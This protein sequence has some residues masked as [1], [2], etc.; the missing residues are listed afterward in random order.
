MPSTLYGKNI[1]LT[2]EKVP[3][4]LMAHNIQALGG[5]PIILPVMKI[6]HNKLSHAECE[7]LMQASQFDWIVFTSPNGVKAFMDNVKSLN[8]NLTNTKIAVVGK[9]NSPSGKCLGIKYR[10]D[11]RRIYSGKFGRKFG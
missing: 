5:N 2:R 3:S 7:I 11:T 6:I 1:L 4:E 9:K 8:I 10:F